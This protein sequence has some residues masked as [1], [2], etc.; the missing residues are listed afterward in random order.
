[1]EK[2]VRN[3]GLNH[4]P[5]AQL[6]QLA[7]TLDAQH[8]A[9]TRQKVTLSD[10]SSAGIFLPTGTVIRPYEILESETGT[11][12]L[13]VPA[14]E[15]VYVASCT[16]PLIFARA[17]YHLGNRHVPLEIKD[18]ELAF[19][20]DP[21]LVNLCPKLGLEVRVESRP[22]VPENGAYHQHAHAHAHSHA[23]H[24]HHH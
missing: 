12:V 11:K 23:D 21:V 2:F 13:V 1:M 4:D 24:E 19:L 14:S 9:V 10:G 3:L 17:C 20:P 5:N 6:P 15:E 18:L 8:R 22:F 7:M 16:D